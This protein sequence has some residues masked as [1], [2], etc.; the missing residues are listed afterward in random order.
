M[1]SPPRTPEREEERQRRLNARTLVIASAASASAAAVTSQ[2][3]IAGT[4]I[5]AAVSPVIVALVSELLHRPSER[6]ARALTSDQPALILDDAAEPP[7]EAARPDPEASRTAEAEPGAP[8][9]ATGP[10]RVYRQPPQSPVRPRI[11]LG[12]VLATA[13]IALA[14][15][16]VV[17]TVPE[18]IAG[19][20]LGKGDSATTFGGGKAR[21]KNSKPDSGQTITGTETQATTP[22]ETTGTDTGTTT[23]RQPPATDTTPTTAPPATTTA[24]GEKLAPRTTP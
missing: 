23:T 1:A 15:A 4:W 2:L 8:A 13:L 3:W 19:Q 12:V 10:V 22:T 24:P 11:A 14:V 5:A 7:A 9:S 20:S 6:I 18:L 21:K 16:V 17:I